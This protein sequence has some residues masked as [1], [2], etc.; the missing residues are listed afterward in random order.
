MS[1][2]DYRVIE[3]TQDTEMNW[4]KFMIAR[5]DPGF[6]RVISEIT[7]TPLFSEIGYGWQDAGLF[8]FDL[9]T[10]EGAYFYPHGSAHADLEKHRIW[11]CPMFEPFLTWLYE[12]WTGKLGDLPNLVKIPA[13]EAPFEMSGHRRPGPLPKLKRLDWVTIP[14]SKIEGRIEAIIE[15]DNIRR[16]LV[17]LCQQE[18]PDH[19]VRETLFIEA[20]EIGEVW[21]KHGQKWHKVAI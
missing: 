13:A 1:A 8:V 4:G 19:L 15:T 3:V 2:L 10:R 16:Y 17:N 18:D 5:F 9:Q 14:G 21:R 12:N 20:E 11:V 7:K 6:F